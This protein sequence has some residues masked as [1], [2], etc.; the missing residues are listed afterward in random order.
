[1]NIC[2]TIFHAYH[3]IWQ[4]IKSLASHKIAVTAAQSWSC[5]G[6]LTQKNHA[7]K[8]PL[9]HRDFGNSFQPRPINF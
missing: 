9:N 2:N 3:S 8:Q 1:M 4:H 5:L 6:G 7:F